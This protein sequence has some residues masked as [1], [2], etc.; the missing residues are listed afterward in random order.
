MAEASR[1][2]AW[3]AGDR[4]EAYMGRWSRQIAPPFLDW[5]DIGDGLDWLDIG[6]GTGA[7]SAAILVRCDPKSLFAIDPS[8]GFAAAA[9]TTIQDRRAEFHVGDAQALALESASRD[10]IV[11]AL[12]LNF[13]PD[14][15]KALMEMKGVTRAGGIVGLYV[16]DYPGRGVEFL[17]AFWA[18]AAALDPAALELAEDKRFPFC[19]PDSLAKLMSGAGL[20]RVDCAP[21]EMPT[22]F[23][24]F[25]DYWHPFTLGTGPAPSYCANLD[26]EARQRLKERLNGSLPRREDGAIALKARAWALKATA[27]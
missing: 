2:D 26:P 1:H 20:A 9:S 17:D 3:Q 19:T 15:L 6:C 16:W 24:D 18:A 12:M 25:E 11:S 13:V 27:T 22:V 5:L 4:Y 7:L 14:K 8:E 10:I 23:T 21:I